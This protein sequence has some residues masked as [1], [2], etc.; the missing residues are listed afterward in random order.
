M[1]GEKR[2]KAVGVKGKSGRKSFQD[3]VV[4][5][6]VINKSWNRI[7]DLFK[8]DKKTKEDE[9][10]LDIISLEVAKKTIPQEI[11]GGLNGNFIIKWA[12]K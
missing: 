5:A 12:D 2:N 8:K 6:L 3:E 7:L 1:K 10:Q 9:K 11:K 4:K